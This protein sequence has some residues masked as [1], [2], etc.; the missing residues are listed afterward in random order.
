ILVAL[1]NP[2][3]FRDFPKVSAYLVTF[4][5][6]VTSETAAVRALFGEI[7]ISGHLPVSIPGLAQLGDGIQLAATRP[8]PPT[9]DAQ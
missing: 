4:S 8:L 2:Y 9:P 5:T 6:T 7:A 1:G 3:L